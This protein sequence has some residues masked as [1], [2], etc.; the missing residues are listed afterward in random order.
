MF[1]CTAVEREMDYNNIPCLGVVGY[2]VHAIYS[3]PYSVDYLLTSCTK[4]HEIS[5]VPLS[6]LR[7]HYLYLKW[8]EPYRG[9]CEAQGNIC[10]LDTNKNGT[11]CTNKPKTH[12]SEPR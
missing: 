7:E 12:R 9:K 10:S 8:S 11:Q 4:I 6:I 3:D 2:Q 1:N 5:S